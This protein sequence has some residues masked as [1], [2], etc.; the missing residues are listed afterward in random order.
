MTPTEKKG[1]RKGKGGKISNG[2][3]CSHLEWEFADK[4]DTKDRLPREFL[5]EALF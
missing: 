1:L 4:S 5:S 3:I 2:G